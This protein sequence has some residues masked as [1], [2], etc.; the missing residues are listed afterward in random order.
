MNANKL[1]FLREY[2]SINRCRPVQYINE[3]DGAQGPSG[4]PTEPKKLKLKISI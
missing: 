4:G 1:L 3:K 2:N